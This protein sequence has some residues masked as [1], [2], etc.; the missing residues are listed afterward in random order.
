MRAA[1]GSMCSIKKAISGACAGVP[2]SRR[3][4][5]TA[6]SEISSGASSGPKASVKVASGGK[7]KEATKP[8]RLAT[9]A[10]IWPDG[11]VRPAL[12]DENTP[13][14]R[15]EAYPTSYFTGSFP[16]LLS[17]ERQRIPMSDLDDAKPAG[18]GLA[19]SSCRSIAG[20]GAQD[21]DDML[22]GFVQWLPIA[23]RRRLAHSL[24]TYIA[25]QALG[26]QAMDE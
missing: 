26:Q 25:R 9:S 14:P 18:N 21:G 12:Y 10:R 11:F 4:L 16:W 24:N 3:S 13:I 22:A 23:A 7:L 17:A 8:R 20:K 2:A 1:G 6:K 5:V 19:S 15:C